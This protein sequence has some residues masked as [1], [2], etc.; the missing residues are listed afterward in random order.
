M[1]NKKW[2]HYYLSLGWSV[3]PVGRNINDQKGLKAPLLSTWLEYQKKQPTEDEVEKWWT[4]WPEAKIGVVTGL[5]SSLVVIDIDDP[6]KF[7]EL[8]IQLPETA[9]VKSGKG[10]HYYFKS[11]EVIQSTK[12][13][14]KGAEIG[15]I[16]AESGYIIAP[17]SDHHDKTDKIDRQYE[18]L[19]HPNNTSL[20][21]YEN[22][23]TN[24]TLVTNGKK[25][26][27]ELIKGVG[28]GDRNNGAASYIGALLKKFR[29]GEWSTE[30]WQAAVE[31]NKTNKPP[32]SSEELASVF[33]SICNKE[34]RGKNMNKSKDDTFHAIHV[35]EVLK[36]TPKPFP[37]VAKNI[38]P[39]HALTVIAGDTGCG[40]SLISFYFADR[41]SKG[42]DILNNP[43]FATKKCNVLIVDQEMNE[44]DY[45]DRAQ[46]ICEGRPN[47]YI[48]YEQRIRVTEEKRLNEIV[49]FAKEKEI[50][51]IM[52][53]TFSKIHQGDENSNTEMTKVLDILVNLA[54]QHNISIVVIHHHNKNKDASGYG[55]G[56]GASAIVDNCASYLEVKSKKDTN[57]MGMQIL[58]MGLEQH[59]NRRSI[60]VSEFGI[61]IINLV[62]GN[63]A[64]EYK[65]KMAQANDILEKY[66]TL[67]FG[68]IKEHPG[69]PKTHVADNIKN[70]YPDDRALTYG[71]INDCIESLLFRKQIKKIKGTGNA[72]LL[73]PVDD[74]EQVTF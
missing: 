43:E 13:S 50:G 17:P 35:E 47:I 74:I 24:N 15:D 16:K 34:R 26:F 44:D 40:K 18:W 6:I 28:S 8:N 25:D 55:K 23:F 10:F 14:S 69:L 53:D 72:K 39:E 56:R 66:M 63:L 51:L 38:I 12:L 42:K 54:R 64:F 7:K 68:Y 52:F 48:A 37:W 29:E 20:A 19:K 36:M 9:M 46:K 45:I 57:E 1:D 5:V 31:W 3:I 27:K 21:K 30:V 49:E 22:F 62:N 71:I 41:I 2:A 11:I 58:S 33:D 4:E 61:E 59:K 60:T 73:A 65:D 32:L 67:V 70:N